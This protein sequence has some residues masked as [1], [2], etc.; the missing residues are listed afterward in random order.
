MAG[1]D[2]G[3][4]L[5]GKE[6]LSR[7]DA[8]LREN[9][10]LLKT[11]KVSSVEGS[12]VRVL[13]VRCRAIE[14]LADFLSDKV[15][16]GVLAHQHDVIT[17]HAAPVHWDFHPENMLLQKDGSAVVID[18]TGFDLTD[19]RFDLAWTLLLIGCNEHPKWRQPVLREYERQAGRK[20]DGLEFF[21]VAACVRRLFTVIVSVNYGAEQLGMRPGAEAIMRRQAPS[22]ARVYDL[23]LQRT[24]LRIPEVDRRAHRSERTAGRARRE[25]ASRGPGR[26]PAIPASSSKRSR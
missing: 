26:A 8:F 19:Y 7:V 6:M 16:I 10:A 21:D 20:V 18:W 1:E 22:M 2:D 24:G 17:E 25:A 23:L 11:V 15:K 5:A 14:G 12:I 9:A 3:K 4:L 13:A